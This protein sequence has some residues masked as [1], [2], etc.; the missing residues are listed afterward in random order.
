[1]LAANAEL[2]LDAEVNVNADLVVVAVVY[3]HVRRTPHLRGARSP[4]W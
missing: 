3:P 2:N 4:Y 1:M